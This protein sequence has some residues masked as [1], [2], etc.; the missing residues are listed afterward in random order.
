MDIQ[1]IK[2][3]AWSFIGLIV[4]LGLGYSYSNWDRSKQ[5]PEGDNQQFQRLLL[6][7]ENRAEGNPPYI[8]NI[9]IHPTV[10]EKFHRITYQQI[11]LQDLKYVTRELDLP[12]P[13]RV[14]YS[15][16]TDFSRRNQPETPRQYLDA[17]I[18][19]NP[20]AGLAYSRAWWEEPKWT[21]MMFTIG[22]VVLIGGAWPML[23][24]LLVG[25]GFGRAPKPTDEY[26]IDRF[27]KAG[28]E[29]KPAT[30]ARDLA[31]EEADLDAVTA[32]YE[33]RM[34]AAAEEDE[35]IEAAITQS[36]SA[37]AAI[38]QLKTGADAEEHQPLTQ[39]QQEDK[40]Y[41]GEF[42]PVA[43]PHV[44]KSEEE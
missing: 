2:W 35:E 5:Y 10:S 14:I 9:R 22:S 24:R 23:L 37:P 39:Q 44:P 12:S 42:Y 38:R 21:Y 15:N 3:W 32:A 28:P 36:Q 17:V 18:A 1:N 43:R 20:D 27:G 40:D 29:I 31:A 4:G 13:Y 6:A 41:K 26:D 16:N 33:A 19:A 8:T 30:P 34:K 7:K 25:A 11:D